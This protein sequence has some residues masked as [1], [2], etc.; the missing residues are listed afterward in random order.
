MYSR[1][2]WWTSESITVCWHDYQWIDLLNIL[3]TP[4]QFIYPPSI[5]CWW[6]LHPCSHWIYCK[7]SMQWSGR[8]NCCMICSSSQVPAC[9]RQ[10][11]SF[12]RLSTASSGAIQP[13]AG[14][15]WTVSYKCYWLSLC[16]LTHHM[17]GPENDGCDFFVSGERILSAAA[18]LS[19]WPI[20]V[21]VVI[22]R[23]RGGW[24]LHDDRLRMRGFACG[25]LSGGCSVR[26]ITWLTQC[27][28]FKESCALLN[29]MPI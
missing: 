12:Y 21:G 24:W 26:L 10:V 5:R 4:R 18:Y 17:G 14:W 25:A 16:A 19:Y 1:H 9:R 20:L 7:Y 8:V 11:R 29:A 2:L 15:T 28:V 27:K 13:N 23:Y 22:F 6:S 3:E